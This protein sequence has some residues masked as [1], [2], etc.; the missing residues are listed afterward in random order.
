M[1]T[2]FYFKKF[3]DILVNFY[4]GLFND[5]SVYFMVNCLASFKID[6]VLNNQEDINVFKASV[7]NDIEAKISEQGR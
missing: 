6:K 5:M 2:N 7:G 4:A 3:L 1:S